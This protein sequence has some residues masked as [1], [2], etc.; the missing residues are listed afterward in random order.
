MYKVTKLKDANL[1]DLEQPLTPQVLGW[2]SQS[3]V[4][5]A[6][7]AQDLPAT[8]TVRDALDYLRSTMTDDM[9]TADAIQDSMESFRRTLENAGFEGYRHVGGTFTGK[10]PHNVEIF[11]EPSEQIKIAIILNN[12]PISLNLFILYLLYFP[13]SYS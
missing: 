8:S 1:F 2:F 12:I 13:L 10:A 11:W 9:E 4:F 6:D 3:R 7:E 5:K